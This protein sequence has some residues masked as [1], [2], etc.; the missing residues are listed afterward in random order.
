MTLPF[1]VGLI[2]LVFPLLARSQ[3]FDPVRQ[4]SVEPYYENDPSVAFSGDTVLTVWRIISHDQNLGRFA[5]ALSTDHGQTWPLRGDVPPPPPDSA[6][7]IGSLRACVDPSGAFCVIAYVFQF[8]P[9][10]FGLAVYRPKYVGGTLQWKRLGYLTDTAPKYEDI[11]RPLLLSG[12]ST[13]TL[14]VFYT[15]AAK[16]IE[17]TRSTDGGDTW[18]YPV[19]MNGGPANGTAAAFGPDGELYVAWEDFA[20]RRVIGRKSLDDG[21]SFASEFVVAPIR[22]D[23]G[24]APPAWKRNDRTSDPYELNS[25]AS[26][27]AI[28]L[29]VD[30]SSGPRRGMLYCTWSE[31]GSGTLR[32]L[33]RQLYETEPNDRPEFAMPLLPGDAVTGQIRS[34]DLGGPCDC[35]FFTFPAL[36]G[37]VIQITGS[38]SSSAPGRDLLGISLVCKDAQDSLL[39]M[40]AHGI[41][42]SRPTAPFLFTV[43]HDGTYYLDLGCCAQY[44]HYYSFALNIVDIDPGSASQD[45]RDVVLVSS[46][47]GGTTWSSKVRV[48]DEP[49][50][51]D[52]AIPG[53]GVT[54]DGR[55]HVV[56]YD[57]RDAVGCPSIVSTYRTW[58]E[59]GGLSFKPSERLH[60]S[61]F[62]LRRG[63]SSWRVGDYILMQ[64]DGANL[65][66]F[67]DEATGYKDTDIFYTRILSDVSTGIVA[68]RLVAVANHG[69]I[70]L[71][72]WADR[73]AAIERFVVRRAVAGSGATPE[74]VGELD[75]QGAGEEFSYDDTQAEPGVRYE[76][77]VEVVEQ[78]GTR[79]WLGPVVAERP[80]T[81][82]T[83]SLMLSPNPF[84]SSTTIR[85]SDHP[86]TMASVR[87]VDISGRVVRRLGS[88]RLGDGDATLVWDGRDDLAE[89][90]HPG[91]Y[92]VRAEL[93]TRELIRR[94][95]KIR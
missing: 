44:S 4:F 53:V 60:L 55:V 37:T 43:P 79:V 39:E 61:T 11:D 57:R 66:T 65:W 46:R 73:G 16:R 85:L 64:P 59:D 12:P 68:D 8:Q 38:L 58:S 33:S 31:Y 87:V 6:V 29:A 67:W 19:I 22:D 49:P 70:R 24:F 76:Y 36:R 42:T 69:G 71:S 32:P 56:W 72:W 54:G 7:L 26:P 41:H 35:D 84:L 89:P 95:V 90:V 18:S 23:L 2:V 30:R 17:Y 63:P 20:A 93:A 50:W 25:S 40:G 47:D 48:N 94:L 92:M 82:T 34:A 1:L 13:N 27:A 62:D 78:G 15:R 88:V 5:W 74:V 14:H 86:G 91:V 83:P 45:H 10:T 28:S 80:A 9:F 77:R 52:D 21:L 75:A 81:V 3:A 51:Y